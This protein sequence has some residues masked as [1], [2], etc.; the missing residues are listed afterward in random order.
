MLYSHTSFHPPW[1]GPAVILILVSL[2]C[3]QIE[4]GQ[5]VHPGMLHNRSELDFVKEKLQ[6]GSQPWKAALEKLQTYPGADLAWIPKPR[7]D[8]V[9]G[10]GDNP[11]IGA[12]DMERD[13]GAAYAHAL[14]WSLTGNAAYARK[15]V[16]ILNAW[17]GTLKTVTGHDARLLVGMTGLMYLN[18]AEIIR[19]T[20]TE[21]TEADQ[22][23]F[24]DML[25]NVYYPI[26]KDFFPAANGNWDASMIQTMLAMGVFLDDTAIFNRGVVHYL[27]GYS[28][29]ALNYYVN[30]F[31]ESQESGR[32]QLHTQMGLGFLSCAAE[33]GWKQGVDLYG[34]LDNRLALGLEYTAQY[35]LGQTVRYEPYRS[36]DGA[37]NNISISSNSRGS[38]R[39][40]YERV[41]QHYHVRK[42]M[43]MP[44]TKQVVDRMSPEGWN[45]QHASWGTLLYADL[46]AYPMGYSGSGAASIRKPAE[47]RTGI[48]FKLSGL[49][50]LQVLRIGPGGDIRAHDVSGKAWEY[51]PSRNGFNSQAVR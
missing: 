29:G 27:T 25:H 40:I 21:W 50:R 8:V 49:G 32:D 7:A 51:F 17:S 13:G 42:G 6:S 11:D 39:P 4:S 48:D 38:F 18:A 5:F 46:P 31:G 2:P 36:I 15:A 26:I 35:N 22:Q 20:F 3:A 16:E 10:A 23:R 43:A 47:D 14:Q 44:F 12:G 34:A 24:R 9:R 1:I 45:I 28:N 41:Y 37:Y 19:H 33:I 30:A